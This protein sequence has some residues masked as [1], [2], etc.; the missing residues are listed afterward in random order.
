MANHKIELNAFDTVML[1]DVNGKNLIRVTYTKVVNSGELLNEL[2]IQD[3]GN[4]L[5]TL[6]KP[7]E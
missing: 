7:S 4:V 1:I 5:I 3:I 2:Y 6:E